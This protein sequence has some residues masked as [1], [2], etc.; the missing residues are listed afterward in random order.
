MR[1]LIVAAGVSLAACASWPLCALAAAEST[2]DLPSTTRQVVL[3]RADRGYRWKIV[4][5]P[6][7]KLG[8]HEVLVHVHAVALNRGDV[9]ILGPD[10]GHDHSGLVPGS[11][12]AGEV[13]AVGSAVTGVRRGG[14]VTNTY[15]R[16]W[17]SGP[18]SQQLLSAVYGWTINGL[19]SDYV[20]LA[21]TAVVPIAQGLSDEEA[22]TLPTAGLTAWTA[23]TEGRKLKSGDSVLVQ[24]TGGVAMFAVQFAAGMGARVIVT[25]SSDDKLTRVHSL[26]ASDG[27]NYRSVP[28][29]AE[30]VRE[31][32]Q[33]R[34]VD[35]VVDLNGKETLDQSVQSLADSGA[36]SL[37]GGLS[38]YDGAL[39][40][41]ALLM[42]RVRVQGIF[43]GSRADFERMNA[44][45]AEHH[46]HPVIDR[47]F[48]LAQYAE[49][50]DYLKRGNF[51]GKI[52]IRL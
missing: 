7:P 34:G 27:I 25:S 14:R 42:K 1:A 50:L 44:F 9:D 51:I 19:L 23:V 36:L 46:I 12:A 24:G 20:V 17:T 8:D 37:V 32:T 2:R 6:L 4:E 13:V 47:S 16:N 11:D 43:V 26:G 33:G 21:D 18:Y 15:F 22:S 3:E 45:I 5:V 49:A 28:K 40:A 39:P 48:P 35:L 52:V 31:I 29:W 41:E 38:G 10:E 30:R